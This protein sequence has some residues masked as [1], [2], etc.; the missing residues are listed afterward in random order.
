MPNDLKNSIDGIES[1]EKETAILQSKINRL[2]ELL[3]KQ[4]RV[5]Q[6]LE[7]VIDEQR[8]KIK[9]MYDVPE[10]VLELK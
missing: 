3:E 4:K 1:S 8:I 6:S 10:D 5:I 9:R 7:D 2:Q